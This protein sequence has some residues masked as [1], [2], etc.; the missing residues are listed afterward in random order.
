MK[1]MLMIEGMSCEH[2]VKA[3]T[4]ALSEIGAIDIDIDLATGTTYIDSA[5]DIAEEALREAVHEAGYTLTSI[6]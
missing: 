5:L 2:C 1:R 3:V 6:N 4:E